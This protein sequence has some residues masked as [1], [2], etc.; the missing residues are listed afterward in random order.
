[1]NMITEA[2]SYSETYVRIYQTTRRH[3]TETKS[4]KPNVLHNLH[5]CIIS[6]QG[7][8]YII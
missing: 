2:T 4:L 8:G 3:V 1:M 7:A 5:I 6:I